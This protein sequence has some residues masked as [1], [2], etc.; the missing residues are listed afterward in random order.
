MHMRVSEM[1]H[2]LLN[3]P[4]SRTVR[5]IKSCDVHLSNVSFNDAGNILMT[6]I[7]AF[8]SIR[9]YVSFGNTVQWDI[10]IVLDRESFNSF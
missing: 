9:E 8:I 5:L 2:Q 10:A 3:G 7:A 4:S 1:M 6:S